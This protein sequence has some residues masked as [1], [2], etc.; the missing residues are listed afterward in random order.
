MAS[1]ELRP[2]PIA[3]FSCTCLRKKRRVGAAAHDA[4]AQRGFDR[5]IARN[6]KKGELTSAAAA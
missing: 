2:W 6:L 1:S 5:L 3:Q 4:L